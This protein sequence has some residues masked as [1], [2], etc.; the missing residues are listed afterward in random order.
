MSA[1]FAT[2]PDG[3]PVLLSTLKTFGGADSTGQPQWAALQSRSL[4]QS[5]VSDRQY[6]KKRR[7]E[8]EEG[9]TTKEE[10]PEDGELIFSNPENKDRDGDVHMSSSQILTSSSSQHPVRSVV[11]KPKS[12]SIVPIPPSVSV[13]REAS[14]GNVSLTDFLKFVYGE[15]ERTKDNKELYPQF[16]NLAT[17][18]DLNALSAAFLAASRG[19]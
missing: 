18:N 1:D 16:R 10:E 12:V 13:Q 4:P 8:D 15:I 17:W 5:S 6:R 9:Q 3:Q 11:L 19:K 14:G 2:G 7:Y